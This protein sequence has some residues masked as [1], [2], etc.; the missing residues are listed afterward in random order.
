MSQAE[1]IELIV[2]KRESCA[3]KLARRKLDPADECRGDRGR[4][5]RGR[6]DRGRGDARRQSNDEAMDFVNWI[7]SLND[8]G[9]ARFVF[10]WA[11]HDYVTEHGGEDEAQE[12]DSWR[13]GVKKSML[14]VHHT[15][16]AMKSNMDTMEANVSAIK[17]E[18]DRKVRKMDAMDKKMDQILLHLSRKSSG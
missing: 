17:S 1:F 10:G 5:D 12:Q 7:D 18:L 3:E 2:G 9:K 14:R 8:V 13:R 6:G 16:T 15:A 11:M 4:G